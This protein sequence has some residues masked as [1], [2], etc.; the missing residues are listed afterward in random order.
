MSLLQAWSIALIPLERYQLSCRLLF[1]TLLR[2]WATRKLISRLAREIHDL[3]AALEAADEPMTRP[4][5][6]SAGA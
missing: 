3:E 1:A 2:S 4:L 5:A 6:G